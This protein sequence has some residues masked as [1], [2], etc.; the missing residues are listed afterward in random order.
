MARIFFFFFL[1]SLVGVFYP[2]QPHRC[3]MALPACPSGR[4]TVCRV[5]W[6]SLPAPLN[7]MIY[8]V[9]GADSPGQ[10]LAHIWGLLASCMWSYPRFH[11]CCGWRWWIAKAMGSFPAASI[12]WCRHPLTLLLYEW[13]SMA[14]PQSCLS[15]F[16][17]Q[18]LECLP[19]DAVRA[20]AIVSKQSLW[21]H[22]QECA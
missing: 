8:L 6:E 2:R 11:T 16:C 10:S 3:S 14:Q 17:T 12:M 1:E 22:T 21:S 20:K 5:T 9:S 13:M 15:P 19:K 18:T 4:W 7:V